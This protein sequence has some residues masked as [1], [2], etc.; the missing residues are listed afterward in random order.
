MSRI[1]L[2]TAGLVISCIAVPGSIAQTFSFSQAE[3]TIHFTNQD[4]TYSFHGSVHNLLAETRTLIYTLS[5]VTYPDTARQSAVCT[6]LGCYPPRSGEIVIEQEY[7]PSQVDDSVKFYIYNTRCDWTPG[8]CAPELAPIV[9]DQLCDVSVHSASD[10]GER[11]TYR[12]SLLYGEGGIKLVNSLIPQH[13]GL[14]NSYPN[15]FNGQTRVRFALPAA[16]TVS[17]DVFD[18]SG[19]RVAMLADRIFFS[20]GEYEFSWT[21]NADGGHP[22]PSGSYWVRL[23]SGAHV[24]SQPL[25]LIR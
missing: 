13:A 24:S 20:P 8:W 4:S 11:I 15:P 14:I 3:T 12:L 18:I 16:G 21:A 23:T 22:L 5:P 25:I 17:L 9:G 19:R 1:L 10:P 6:Y 7:L 2:F